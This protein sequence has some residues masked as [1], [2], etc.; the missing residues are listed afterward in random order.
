VV[1]IVRRAA[2]LL[3]LGA[4]LP[5]CGGEDLGREP[6]PVAPKPLEPTDYC[7]EAAGYE[8]LNVLDFEGAGASNAVCDVSNPRN[9]AATCNWYAGSDGAHVCTDDPQTSLRPSGNMNFPGEALPEDRCGAAG[10]GLHVV[11]TRVAACIPSDETS[12]GKIGWGANFQV[13]S[14]PIGPPDTGGAA[15]GEPE[16]G[17]DPPGSLFFDASCW[18]GISFWAK[19]NGPTGGSAI[20]VTVSDAWT[21][22]GRMDPE[23]NMPYC[24]TRDGVPDT[25]K[26]DSAGA[27]VS[28]TEEWTLYVLRWEDLKQKGFGVPSVLGRV[29]PGNIKGVTLLISPGDWDIWIDDVAFFRNAP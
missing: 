18:D 10:S 25:R 9:S 29:D 8:F 5:A 4:V 28:L 14:L 12:N 15:C 20:T 23:T 7:R 16:E 13:D 17:V 22:S 24:E 27:A 21:T 1:V 6:V 19:K 26:C 2:A 11:A 3:V